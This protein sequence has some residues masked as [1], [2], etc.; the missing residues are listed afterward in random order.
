[1]LTMK[2]EVQAREGTLILPTYA[3]KA[4]NRNPVFRS[5]YG[6]AHI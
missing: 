6:V 5:Q 3:I 2:E 1:M 4:E